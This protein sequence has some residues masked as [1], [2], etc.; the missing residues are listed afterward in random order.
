MADEFTAAE[1]KKK[2][3]EYNW[4]L[5][6]AKEDT[7]GS[8]LKFWKELKKVIAS[9][10]GDTAVIDKFVDDR[11]TGIEAFAGLYGTQITTKIVDAQAEGDSIVAAEIERAVETNR[12]SIQSIADRYGIR[13]TPDR[14]DELARGKRA[15]GW[16]DSEVLLNLRPDLDATLAAGDTSGMAGD[17][18]NQLMT[19]ASRNGLALSSDTAAKYVANMTLGSQSLED[20]KAELRSTY[21]AGAYPA[22]AKKINE[23]Y[24]PSQI[25]EP[26][27]DEIRGTLE[28]RDIGLDDPLMQSITQRVGA[29]GQPVAVPLYEARKMARAD[30]RWQ[31]TDNAYATYANVAQDILK[32]FGFA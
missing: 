30:S 28:N 29:D 32:T 17:F 18:Q 6:L 14:V 24:D 7:T 4:I 26:Y 23:G 19:W 3:A 31:T 2:K 27:L 5:G 8:V 20:V 16:S 22:W 15:N 1:R 10:E 13:I 25:F 11:L 9:S 12:Q 21:L